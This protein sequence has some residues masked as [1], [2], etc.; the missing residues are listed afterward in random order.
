VVD[1]LPNGWVAY[2]YDLTVRWV[3]DAPPAPPPAG[4]AV[5]SSGQGVLRGTWLFNFEEGAEYGDQNADVWWEQQTAREKVARTAAG[6]AG[7][8]SAA[9]TSPA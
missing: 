5:I 3:T 6:A 7:E 9:S 2:G 8:P 4:A 1:A